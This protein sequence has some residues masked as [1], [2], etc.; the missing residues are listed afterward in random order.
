MLHIAYGHNVATMGDIP[1]W[2]APAL[3]RDNLANAI[4]T[5]TGA[6][7]FLDPPAAL[8]C[9]LAI[10][11]A[12]RLRGPLLRNTSNRLGLQLL[13]M[14]RVGFCYGLLLEGFKLL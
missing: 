13:D 6:R 5:L 10:E 9:V 4:A 8:L 14:S 1:R 11:A 12:I 2:L 7:S 3:A